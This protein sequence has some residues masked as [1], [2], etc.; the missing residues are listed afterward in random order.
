MEDVWAGEIAGAG[1]IGI[2]AATLTVDDS[3]FGEGS[4]DGESD[5][6]VVL[7]D[8]GKDAKKP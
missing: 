2:G 5:S 8:A 6:S 1:S 3:L 4:E 7:E